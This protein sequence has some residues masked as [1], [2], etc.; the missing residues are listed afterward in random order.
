EVVAGC[1][2]AVDL[3]GRTDLAGLAAVLAGAAVV[4]GNDTGPVHLAAALGRRC[5][6][7]FGGESDPA[8]T[9]P[10]GAGVVVV[11]AGDLRGLEVARVVAA[12][13]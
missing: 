11:R 10:R 7:L 8:L 1:A 4:V 3:A 5:V 6:V 2:G 13:G 9:A 12:L